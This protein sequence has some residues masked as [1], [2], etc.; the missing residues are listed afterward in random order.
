[1]PPHNF[2]FFFLF[3]CFPLF[4]FSFFCF[5]Y[6]PDFSKLLLQNIHSSQRFHSVL[7]GRFQ[8]HCLCNM[9]SEK[10]MAEKTRLVTGYR[11]KSSTVGE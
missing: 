5:V 11:H 1:M 4:S 7:M 3:A 9:G 10:V 6:E 8:R 2:F